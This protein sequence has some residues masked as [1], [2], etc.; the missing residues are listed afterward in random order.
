MIKSE[1][2]KRKKRN[3]KTRKKKKEVQKK[4]EEVER[5]RSK[6]ARKNY[7]NKDRDRR[8]KQN[9][10]TGVHWTEAG[11]AQQ[12]DLEHAW[13]LIPQSLRHMPKFK[14]IRGQPLAQQF[15]LIGLDKKFTYIHK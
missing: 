4:R 1:E 14:G 11:V 9:N 7:R 2:K 6:Q 3:R 13:Y 12:R 8:R 15:W 5:R 10:I